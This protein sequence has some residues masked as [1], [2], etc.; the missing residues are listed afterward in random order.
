MKKLRILGL[1]QKCKYTLVTKCSSKKLKLKNEKNWDLA[2]FGKNCFYFY[3][4]FLEEHIV[5][6]VYLHF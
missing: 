5:T 2:K 6:K 1:F 4:N 3:F